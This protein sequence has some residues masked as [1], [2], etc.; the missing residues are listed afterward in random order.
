MPPSYIFRRVHTPI[1]LFFVS[2]P[3]FRIHSSSIHQKRTPRRCPFGAEDE[4]L[5]LCD[6][7]SSLANFRRIFYK[8]PFS[9]LARTRAYPRF[10]L[11]GLLHQKRTPRRCPF[12][13]EDEIRTRATVSHTT[14]LAGEPL[15]PLGYFCMA[16][17]ICAY[18]KKPYYYITFFW[19][20]QRFLTQKRKIL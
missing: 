14:P 12:G 9:L 2:P 1:V 15:E 6:K 7:V 18:S 13:A 20:C 19:T 5:P 16:Q 4:R 10:L 17:Y 11:T 3:F 8:F